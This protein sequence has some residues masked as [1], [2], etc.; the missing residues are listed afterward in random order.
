MVYIKAFLQRAEQIGG[1][2]GHTRSVDYLKKRLII[3][4]RRHYDY[5]V[6]KPVK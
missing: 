6:F 4:D 1:K 5:S 2:E 3:R